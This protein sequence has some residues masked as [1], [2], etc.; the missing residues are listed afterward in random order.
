[1]E[2]LEV[3]SSIKKQ[4]NSKL[5]SELISEVNNQIILCDIEN[6]ELEYKLKKNLKKSIFFFS[7]S[8]LSN[9][10]QGLKKK[11][12]E[13]IT[14]NIRVLLITDQEINVY[15][16][17]KGLF[18]D[19]QIQIFS[20]KEF[21]SVVNYINLE[22][23]KKPIL[24]ALQ[25]LYDEVSREVF[26]KILQTRCLLDPL[27]SDYSLIQEI[28]SSG[29]EYFEDEIY[30]L[31]DNETFVDCGGYTGDTIS[32]F[33]EKTNSSFN[34]IFVFEPDKVNYNSLA[35]Q[36]NFKYFLKVQNNT[37][38]KIHFT[39]NSK[40]VA[41]N[42]G[43]SDKNE[44]VSFYEGL[45]VA[46]HYVNTYDMDTTNAVYTVNE[47]VILDSYLLNESVTLLKLDVEGY[48]LKALEGAKNSIEKHRPK[49]IACV[50]HQD[51]HLWEIIN[52]IHKLVP[53]YRY[54]LRHYNNNL[55][56]TILYAVPE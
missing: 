16:Y 27:N 52:Y 54:Y 55:W 9:D 35:Q 34:K 56:D 7:K 11:F 13:C 36:I 40:I 5:Y 32:N 39:D 30:S 17:L 33:L 49:I 44:Q 51:E 14:E 19:E 20:N 4:I 23:N 48:E 12:E 24:H 42:Y 1:M 41:Y 15:L 37:L 28:K 25:L 53:N 45:G 50:Y 18:N 21:M 31:G 22:K 3:L 2:K 29:V 43:V 10:R 6:K 47:N 38:K 46:S 8:N 26:E